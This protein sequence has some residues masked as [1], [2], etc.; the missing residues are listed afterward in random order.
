MAQSEI[1]ILFAAVVI[2][3]SFGFAV[4][5]D[6]NRPKLNY[7]ERCAV[8]ALWPILVP[9]SLCVKLIAYVRE[10]RYIKP[11]DLDVIQ[12]DINE[13][14]AIED[15]ELATKLRNELAM[16]QNRKAI[17]SNITQNGDH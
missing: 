3:A 5:D 9:Y 14:L 17:H 16:A 7:Y 8:F 13:A 15:Y 11:R 6:R 12:A 10:K 2:I 4:L 1:N